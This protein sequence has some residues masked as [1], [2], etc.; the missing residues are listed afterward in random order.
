MILI[1]DGFINM[2]SRI[3]YNLSKY[4]LFYKQLNNN[5]YIKNFHN[6]M[7]QLYIYLII[8]LF[9]NIK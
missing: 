3:T 6:I 2:Y 5:N 4:N 1:H 7:F 8:V 9:V